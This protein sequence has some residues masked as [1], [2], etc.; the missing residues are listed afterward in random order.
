[1]L[2][3]YATLVT[4]AAVQIPVGASRKLRRTIAKRHNFNFTPRAGYIYVRSRA[5][6][7]R[8][9]DNF[10]EFPAEEIEKGYKTF[11][12]KPAFVNHV[13]DNHKRA[14]G[15]IID[16]H[17]HKDRLADGHPDT[18][19]EVL[20]EIDAKTFPKLAKAIMDK[21]IDRTSMGCDVEYSICSACGNKATTPAEYCQHIPRLK[22]KKISK[23]NPETGEIETHL[24][25]ETC[26]GLRF[27]ENSLLVEEP[28][29]PTAAFTGVE[30][31]SGL[32]KAASKTDDEV[33]GWDD[34]EP[35]ESHYRTH[36]N[37]GQRWDPSTG[38][39]PDND[40]FAGKSDD[41]ACPNHIPTGDEKAEQIEGTLHP[42]D[43]CDDDC[44][45]NHASDLAR[46]IGVH[47]TFNVDEGQDAS[48]SAGPHSDPV[49]R[50]SGSYEVRKP[51]DQALCHYCRTPLVDLGKTSLLQHFASDDELAAPCQGGHCEDYPE[52]HTYREHYDKNEARGLDVW[53]R[54][55]MQPYDGHGAWA[56]NNYS[57]AE[58]PQSMYPEE[59]KHPVGMPG[60]MSHDLQDP[61]T[62]EIGR[63]IGKHCHDQGMT[64]D[65]RFL[66]DQQHQGPTHLSVLMR[67]F[68]DA[69]VLPFKPRPECMCDE[70]DVYDGWAECPVH[71]S[72]HH[73]AKKDDGPSVSGVVLKAKDTGRILMLQRSMKD[74]KDPARGTWEFPGGHHEEGD[75][76]SLHAGI[77]EWEEEVGQPFPTGGVVS[78]TWRSPNGIYQGHVVVIPEE[79]QV[80]LH[81]GRVV[82]NPDDPDG[83]DAEQAAW[84]DPKHAA[85]NPALRREVKKA[86]WEELRKAAGIFTRHLE[87]MP[88]A[89]NGETVCSQHRAD[90]CGHAMSRHY[91]NG[92]AVV[93]S[94]CSCSQSIPKTSAYLDMPSRERKAKAGQEHVH[95]VR[96]LTLNRAT[97][98][99]DGSF[100]ATRE[101]RGSDEQAPRDDWPLRLC[102]RGLAHLH[103]QVADHNESATGHPQMLEVVEGDELDP[104]HYADRPLCDSCQTCSGCGE[105]YEPSD[106]EGEMHDHWT[107]TKG[108]D[109]TAAKHH[110]KE[111]HHHRHP[112][113]HPKYRPGRGWAHG[114]GGVGWFGGQQGYC[115]PN[116]SC[117][118]V[119]TLE[120]ASGSVDAGDGG[121]V[122]GGGDGGGAEAKKGFPKT[123]K[124][125]YCDDQA[126]QRLLW[127]EGMAYI[128]TCDQHDSDGRHQIEVTNKDEVVS[129]KK[130]AQI[131]TSIF[132]RAEEACPECGKPRDHMHI[133]ISPEMRDLMRD[134]HEDGQRRSEMHQHE[135]K[136]TVDLSDPVD[137]KQ[138]LMEA[139]G[140]EDED[141]EPSTSS[142]DHPAVGDRPAIEQ[143]PLTH[144]EVRHAHDWEHGHGVKNDHPDYDGGEPGHFL[145]DSHFHTAVRKTATNKVGCIRC[146][147]YKIPER[148]AAGMWWCRECKEP[149]ECDECGQQ[150]AARH[151]HPRQA[152]LRKQADEDQCP[153]C[154]D[155]GG[156]IIGHD[157]L[158]KRDIYACQGCG[159]AFV[160]L[161]GDDEIALRD[162]KH[163]LG[164]PTLERMS[165]KGLVRHEIPASEVQEGDYLDIG[166]KV[167]VHQTL[168]RDGSTTLAWRLRGSK[169]PGIRKHDADETVKVWRPPAPE[170][171][172]LLRHF[173]ND[174]RGSHQPFEDGDPL[175]DLGSEGTI[176]SDVYEH[177]EWYSFGDHAHAAAQVIHRVRN[178]PD[179]QVTV[180]RAVPHHVHDINRGDW[181]AT[182]PGYAREHARRGDED[183][184][185][186]WKVLKTKTQAKN[187]RSGGSD[188]L[189]WGYYGDDAKNAEVH[190]PGGR[191]A[192]DE[193]ERTKPSYWADRVNEGMQISQAHT[194][195]LPSHLQG[196]K[197]MP[198]H[199]AMDALGEHL[200]QHPPY[201]D[202]HPVWHDSL[203]GALVHPHPQEAQPGQHVVVYRG[204]PD[205]SM[206]HGGD[207]GEV[208]LKNGT[209]HHDRLDLYDHRGRKV[210]WGY[211]T[212][213]LDHKIAIGGSK[214]FYSEHPSGYRAEWRGGPRVHIYEG[215]VPVDSPAMKGYSDAMSSSEVDDWAQSITQ[216][217]VDKALNKWVKENGA[218]YS[219]FNHPLDK[220]SYGERHGFTG[221]RIGLVA[222]RLKATTGDEEDKPDLHKHLDDI[223]DSIGRSEGFDDWKGFN[224]HHR[225]TR[226]MEDLMHR[227]EGGPQHP[228]HPGHFDADDAEKDGDKAGEPYYEVE[229]PAG[230]GWTA[231]DYGGTMVH[232]HHKATGEDTHE[233]FDEHDDQDPEGYGNLLKPG[234][235]PPGFGHD[236][237]HK[238]LHHFVHGDEEE[239][240]GI[241]NYLSGPHGDSR[242]SRWQKRNGYKG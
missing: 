40:T 37:C 114:W 177:P 194:I 50:Q 235:K 99:Y 146:G 203:E 156:P 147:A 121:S 55:K 138:H 124:C 197:D 38:Y 112:A 3:K 159:K 45:W 48:I 232:I 200:R 176:P 242:I 76:T 9:N 73:E 219:D 188:I 129:V 141:F 201:A 134:I 20:H 33:E 39:H 63:E 202:G 68:A 174:Y 229:D 12:G 226:N 205:A 125:E 126:T 36:Q 170:V 118:G 116:D 164:L 27:F 213:G 238:V 120:G 77:R 209:F 89:D 130:I 10:D 210:Q 223:F 234:H 47:H 95:P 167:R 8:T 93:C 109:F 98:E 16:A 14:R 145:G 94:A 19:V 51:G 241:A 110:H 104:N 13:N 139:H 64:E 26:Y 29:D 199:E 41:G 102:E 22:G 157:P 11:I 240:G 57:C 136:R 206:I 175:H 217:H 173:A 69:K 148:D 166:G 155:D 119:D 61:E 85:E 86:P 193:Y 21:R 60:W 42:A 132:K 195:D 187:I 90:G 80:T 105:R 75:Q 216:K 66:L 151:Q 204:H 122:G 15:V 192:Q 221:S 131:I 220:P 208:W 142:L 225:Y 6:S 179:A 140:W 72:S 49:S 79:A 70:P 2:T 56:C 207:D 17:L 71:P 46:G 190:H 92:Q 185:D 135:Q 237:L 160:G 30:D 107:A 4:T 100:K 103:A 97:G 108:Q 52:P 34:D 78:H 153:H 178:R 183:G 162:S 128:P 101:H 18:W 111:H 35:D 181:V 214:R 137:L 152:S 58:H 62:K 239:N 28:A 82:P 106:S 212:G 83:D 127:A 184:G 149:L 233:V 150:L 180:Y 143:R 67:H 7:S 227:Y 59:G 222:R 236:E 172:A 54:P 117:R 74:E 25:R 123:Q 23:R 163:A 44:R 231:R 91:S 165:A 144:A 230:S 5:I 113:S 161:G 81:D 228:L 191:R 211:P 169:A 32:D 96:V 218:G 115:C 87:S 43:Y 215:D 1:M 186:D 171:T 189:E 196:I 154:G 31:Y 182:T 224:D 24:I 168:T 88:S 158:L 53:G 84:W 198:R 133:Q 65:A